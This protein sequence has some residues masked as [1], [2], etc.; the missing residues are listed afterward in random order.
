MNAKQV[1][2]L[3]EENGWF[4]VRQKGSHRIFKH[5]INPDNIPVADHGTKDI[6]IGTLKAILKKAG[7]K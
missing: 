1:I 2:K 4:E 5:P 7:I 6:P 3:L